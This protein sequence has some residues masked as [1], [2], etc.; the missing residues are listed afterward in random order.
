MEVED[1]ANVSIDWASEEPGGIR[2]SQD[3]AAP[4]R[5]TEE[6]V[7]APQSALQKHIQSVTLMPGTHDGRLLDWVCG[8]VG[9]AGAGG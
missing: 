2:T 7:L 8:R 3:L 9:L 6:E 1:Q 5:V 4:R